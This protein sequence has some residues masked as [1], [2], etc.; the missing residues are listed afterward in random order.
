VHMLL[1]SQELDTSFSSRAHDGGETPPSVR[2]R[3]HLK[4]R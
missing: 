2:P 1:A 3:A 4:R